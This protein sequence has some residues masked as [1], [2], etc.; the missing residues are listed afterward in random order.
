MPG[1][2]HS[3]CNAGFVPNY[4]RHHTL[5]M[6]YHL[7]AY[8]SNSLCIKPLYNPKGPFK[9]LSFSPLSLWAAGAVYR[10][11]RW[12]RRPSSSFR[13]RKGYP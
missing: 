10:Y 4:L 7:F 2:L 5:S 6:F 12:P 1:G 3:S 8:G 13:T 11:D 9:G